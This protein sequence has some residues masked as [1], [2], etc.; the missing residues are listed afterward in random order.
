MFLLQCVAHG[1]RKKTDTAPRWDVGWMQLNPG[2]VEANLS[3][4]A[5]CSMQLRYTWLQ[6]R[7][8]TV[9]APLIVVVV[10]ISGL[11]AAPVAARHCWF[12]VPLVEAIS[13]AG[14]TI[15]SFRS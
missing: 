11:L 14:C 15:L 13:D 4:D 12:A 5:A 3:P 6:L 1:R 8:A 10:P 7:Q 9:L 2:Q